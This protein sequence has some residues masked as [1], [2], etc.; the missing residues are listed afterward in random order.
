LVVSTGGG[1]RDFVAGV[2]LGPT[3][4]GRFPGEQAIRREDFRRWFPQMRDLGIQAIRVYTIMP[5]LFYEELVAFNEANATRPL[6][7][8]H[9]VWI[10]EERFRQTSDLYDPFVR[11]EFRGEIES[12]VSVVH[13]DA[14]LP[15]R[16]GHAAGTYTV[17]VSNWVLGWVIG[18]EMDPQA[19]AESDRK[20]ADVDRF[21]GTFFRAGRGATATESWMAEMLDHLA[22]LEAARGV[23]MPL[24][25]ANWPTTDP[26]RHPA[27]PLASED[28][29][30]ID[31]NHVAPTEAWPGGYFASYHAY[32]YYPDFQRYEV[33]IA[34]FEVDGRPDPYAGYLTKLRDHHS[35]IPV[36]ITEFGVPSGMASAH[37]GPWG[38][39]QGGHS[40]QQQ[41]AINAEL[42][43]AIEGA[44]MS[45]GFYFEW[46]DEWV[47]FTWNTIDYEL[48]RER[49]ALW[50]NPWTNEAH[51]G[52]V[53]V[54]PGDWPAAIVD[55]VDTEWATNGS[56]VIL[57]DRGSVREVRAARDEGYLY[58]RI[59]LDQPESWRVHPIVIGL[60]VI[61]G[62]SGGLPEAAGV[63]PIADYAVVLGPGEQNGRIMVRASND[64]YLLHYGWL[65]DYETVD[66]SWFLDGSGVWNVQRLVVNR[67]FEI[68]VTHESLPAEVVEPGR[69]LFGS[70]DPNDPAF[71]SRTT[72]AAQA[73]V[74]EV[75][76]PFQAIGF[77]DPSSLQG[78]RILR[79][80]SV[81]T[82][83]VDRVGITVVHGGEVFGTAGYG[84]EPWQ[85][86][87]WH[88]RL[89]AGTD[90]FATAIIT[91]NGG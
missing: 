50:M 86:P 29:V 68:P 15:E 64:P 38:R 14:S 18:I 85:Q 72:W 82:E 70:S 47:K 79:D 78:Y 25:F 60:D 44:G 58:L 49:R 55:G 24:A 6:L 36:L 75:R 12:A 11:D 34:D 21:S 76:L 77:S 23:T 81:D 88:E 89:K 40:E 43:G 61:D 2:N 22:S 30:S 31:P 9:G 42:L 19:T 32:P 69:M 35:E 67:P 53:A 80:G 62:D 51:F 28:M 56:Q 48:P 66:D 20:N 13:G 3:I 7:L 65:H 63:D 57:E 54:E 5:P 26:L 71:D 8:V 90:V 84:W 83:T 73:L 33:G 16:P 41:M 37:Y 39:N 74:V 87:A 27:E 52:L 1:E 17:D 59:R 91:A 46:V 45:G 10:P 4:P